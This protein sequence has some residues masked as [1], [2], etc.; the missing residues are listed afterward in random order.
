VTFDGRRIVYLDRVIVDLRD[1]WGLDGK[2]ECRIDPAAQRMTMMGE[3]L[4][5]WSRDGVI[6]PLRS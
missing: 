3:L 5:R 4:E 2:A 1:K 6:Y